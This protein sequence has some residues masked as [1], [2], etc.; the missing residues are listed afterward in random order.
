MVKNV[1]IAMEI[2]IIGMSVGF[3]VQGSGLCRA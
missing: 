2:G 1:V 3:Q